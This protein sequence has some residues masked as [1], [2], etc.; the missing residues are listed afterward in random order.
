[1]K[2]IKELKEERA[3]LAARM[4][5][6]LDVAEEREAKGFTAEERAKYDGLKKEYETLDERIALRERM[7]GGRAHGEPLAHE[8]TA[9]HGGVGDRLERYAQVDGVVDDLAFRVLLAHRARGKHA[10]EEALDR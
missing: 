10:L 1:M 2:T 6:M 4:S 9:A 7:P 8:A 3:A 5:Q